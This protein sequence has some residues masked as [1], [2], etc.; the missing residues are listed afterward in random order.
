[1]FSTVR[2]LLVKRLALTILLSSSIA[3]WHLDVKEIHTEARRLNRYT[4]VGVKRQKIAEL[5]QSI[6]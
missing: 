4:L 3:F 1:M 5:T 6:H 2:E